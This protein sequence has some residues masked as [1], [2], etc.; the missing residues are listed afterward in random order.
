[1]NKDFNKSI[2]NV[3][4]IEKNMDKKG[5]M[6]YFNTVKIYKKIQIDILELQN[7]VSEVKNLL[8]GFKSR[9]NTLILL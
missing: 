6:Q 5:N 2:I 7:S 9:L 3:K 8:D 4:K 1:M